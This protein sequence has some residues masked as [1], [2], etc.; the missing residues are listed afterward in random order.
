MT[1]LP[2]EH[3][4]PVLGARIDGPGTRFG[5]F[6][7]PADS[8]AVRV[9]RSEGGHPREEPMAPLGEGYFEAYLPDVRSGALYKFVVDG[10]EL[11]DPY[12]RFLPQGV[13]GP[14]QVTGS[15]YQWRAGAGVYRPLGEHVIYELHVGTFSESGTYDGVREHLP[16]LVDLGVTAIELLPLAA[17]PGQRGWGYEGVA[18][19]APFAP[20]GTPDELRRLVDAAHSAGL[21]VFLD[22][23][24]NHFGPAGNTLSAYSPAYF[25]SDCHNAWGDAPNYAHPVVRRMVL[26]NAAYWLGEFRFDGLRLDATHAVV[27]PSTPHILR[28]LAEAVARLEPHKLLIAEDNRNDPC[29]V[30]EHGLDAVWADD[31]HHQLR[32]TLTGERDGYYSAFEPG[33]ADLARVITRGWL[34]EGQPYAPLDGTPRGKPAV[35]LE[36]SAFVYC[37]Q[38]HDQVGN[39]AL[40]DRLSSMVSPEQYRAVSTL[41][42]FLPMTPL[43]FM[44][45]EWA[46]SSPFLFFTDHDAELGRLILEGRRNEFASF[47]AFADPEAR[48]CIPDPQALTTFEASKLKWAERDEGEHRRSLELHKNLLALRASDPVLRDGGRRQLTAE[49]LDDVLVVR[50]RCEAGTRTLLMNFGERTRRLLDL[51]PTVEGRVLLRSDLGPLDG[52]DLPKHTAVIVLT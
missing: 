9:L 40:G 35:D 30:T 5:L 38:N 7:D 46:A 12:A 10:R 6:A 51:H 2:Q 20:Y 52:S 36:A 24:Y 3:S 25:T 29:L 26:D 42:L 37:L 44:G 8:C 39:R 49:H 23:V 13:D 45:Q 17:F 14:A 27:D 50:R 22:V 34:Y 16:Q 47:A 19:F 11:T 1:P 43:L 21:A 4:P 32:V 31:F 18:L 28:E 41:L 33:V 48:S 15:T